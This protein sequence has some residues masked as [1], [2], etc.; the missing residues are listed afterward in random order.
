MARVGA[1]VH[2]HKPDPESGRG[3]AKPLTHTASLKE[4]VGLFLFVILSWFVCN[5]LW[6]D[7]NIWGGAVAVTEG[8][9]RRE[10][11]GSAGAGSQCEQGKLIN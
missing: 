10:N 3:E 1:G 6:S 11:E 2:R 9:N 8:E 5:L 7:R 4:Y